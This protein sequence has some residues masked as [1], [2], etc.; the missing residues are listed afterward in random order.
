MA[1][2]G[3]ARA[4]H[5]RQ[6]S[7]EAE[8]TLWRHLRS[9]QLAGC[10]FRRQAPLGRYIV[11]FLCYE[12]N[13]VIEVDGGQHQLRSE[14]DS[15]RTNWLEACGFRVARFWNNQVLEETEAVLD[16]ILRQLQGEESPSP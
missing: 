8:K 6:S 10:K 13:L 7:T 5:L 9:R 12:R 3:A 2:Q 1:P 11:D 14:E 15:I 4:R 16:A